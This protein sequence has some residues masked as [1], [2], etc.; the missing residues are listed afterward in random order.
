MEWTDTW[1][2]QYGSAPV[3]DPVGPRDG[4][5]KV[6]RGGSFRTPATS[7]RER[8][9]SRPDYSFDFVGVRLVADGPKLDA[10]VGLPLY[11]VPDLEEGPGPWSQFSVSGALR[12][13][14]N[15]FRDEI[16]IM[17]QVA[18]ADPMELA[19]Y[20]MAGQ[21]IVTLAEGVRRVGE[22]VVI[23]DGHVGGRPTASGV[24]VCR[25]RVGSSPWRRARSC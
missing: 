5:G 23:W 3:T 8:F 22:H 1:Y 18:Q 12:L 10:P 15:P 7:A 6:F 16:R 9:A 25:L 21:Q 14:P 20:N 24:Y 11:A 13:Q 19:I 2:E 4:A 17:Y